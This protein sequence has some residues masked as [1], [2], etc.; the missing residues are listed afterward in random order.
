MERTPRTLT[1]DEKKAAE[2]AYR[3]ECPDELWSD[4]AKKIYIGISIA[5]AGKSS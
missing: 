2:A 4:T 1:H 3:G 5:L